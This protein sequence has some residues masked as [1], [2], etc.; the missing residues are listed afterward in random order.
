MATVYLAQDLKHERPVALKVLRPALAMSMGPD[1]FRR[2]ITT[3]ARLQ[4]PHILSVHDSGETEGLLWYTMPYVR[5]ESLRDRLKREGRLPLAEALRITSEAGRALDYAHREGVI[6]R[7]IKPENILLTLDGDT[8]VADFGIARAL[9]GPSENRLTQAG[10]ALGTPAYMAPEQATG[11]RSVDA[12][13]DQYSLAIVCYEMLLG[14]PPFEGTT[15]AAIIARR[16]TSPMPVLRPE[17]PEVP[18]ATERAL[19]RAMALD[20]A[21]RFGSVSELVRALGGGGSTPVSGMPA[22]P[23][24]WGAPVRGPGQVAAPVAA[25]VRGTPAARASRPRWLVAGVLALAAALV[26]GGLALRRSGEA[27]GDAAA[28]TRLAVLPFENLGDSA[29][30]YFADGM[31]DAVRGKLTELGGL[32][33]IARSSSDEYRGS[34]KSPQEIGRE[35]GARYLLTGT[36]RW[37]REK[38]GT[39]RVQVSPELVD[40]G[41]GAAPTDRWQE[42]FDASLTDVFKVQSDIAGQVAAALDV[43]LGAGEEEGL[44]QRP[45]ANL[46]AYDAFL[47]GEAIRAG[48]ADPASLRRAVARYDAAVKQDPAF[49]LAWARLAGAR[50]ALYIYGTPDPAM[51]RAALDAL[52][53]ARALAPDAPAT[54]T[55]EW[56]IQLRQQHDPAAA[57]AAVEPALAGSPND[58]TLL[59]LVAEAELALGRPAPAR[60]HAARAVALDPRAP[61]AFV[62][63]GDVDARLGHWA[64]V[65][66]TFERALS[67]A[68]VNEL[69][70]SRAVE[71]RL[72][73]GDL[74]GAR[75]VLAQSYPTVDHPRL[76]AFA[77]GFGDVGWALDG[78]DRRLVLGLPAA[79]FDGDVARWTLVRAQMRTWGGDTAAAAALGD[80]A[81]RLLRRQVGAASSDA[82]IRADL[83]TALAY[84]GR[85]PE[86]I[87]QG[88]R[89]AELMPPARDFRVGS[90]VRFAL[91]RI[92]VRAGERRRAIA[93]LE[94]LARQ[95]YYLSPAWLRT[96]PSLAP[97]RGDPEFERLA[98]AR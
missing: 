1:R 24:P 64:E 92:L 58:A 8:L 72:L 17:R 95:P 68:R 63:L 52:A 3:A 94:P 11:D 21:E 48:S 56:A 49:A 45:T 5:G 66:A 83:G 13:T 30:A 41:G 28:G 67:S 22:I 85:F 78:G 34:G 86:A 15:G 25:P 81:A 62:T 39:S 36:V 77:A 44:R 7:D 10:L 87:A 65:H 60:E 37:A 33:V 12:R 70:I 74:A 57:L 23:D 91:A 59:R 38:N 40:V 84:A 32:Q 82:A 80:S 96:D 88:E 97:L 50:S 71:A 6:H 46:Q 18:E 26:S 29:N 89:A 4:H 79:A 93:L 43:A 42:S 2:E 47:Q 76:V 69:L 35:L 55:A 73:E 75:A 14:R 51:G 19:Q 27:A 16:F 54:A 53:R 9:G 90:E 98:R 61:L 20:P 31:A